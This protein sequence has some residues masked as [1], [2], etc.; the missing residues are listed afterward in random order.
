MTPVVWMILVS[1]VT[2]IAAATVADDARAE[3]FFGMLA[4]LA[5]VVATWIL[6][7]RGQRRNPLQVTA[8]LLKAFAGK[9]IFFLGYVTFMIAGIGVQP[10]PFVI[11]LTVYFIG[12]YAVEAW[13]LHR[14][15]LRRMAPSY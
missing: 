13:F 2:A 15:F 14:L 11:S 5:A 4:P 12:L 8:I 10:Q 9:V 1:V 6:V 7:A 3:I